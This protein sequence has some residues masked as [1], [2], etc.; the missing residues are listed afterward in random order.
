[1]SLFSMRISPTKRAWMTVTV[2]V[3]MVLGAT[4][5]YAYRAH[6]YPDVVN[7]GSIPEI[8]HLLP[9]NAPAIMYIDLAALRNTPGSP[10]AGIL[11]SDIKA[12]QAD[13][14]YADFVRDTGFDYQRDLDRAG[15]AFWPVLGK[16]PSDTAGRGQML[17]VAEGRFD[18]QKIGAYAL[19]TGKAISQG[20]HSLYEVPGN[21]AT[22]FEFLS[23][24]RIL[25]ASGQESVNLLNDK[26]EAPFG[27]EADP[28]AEQAQ[29]ES[30]SR[31]G[32]AP[33]FAIVRTTGLPES[34]YDNFRGSP[35][36]GSLLHGLQ[37]IALSG[38]PQGDHVQVVLDGECDSMKT[39]IQIA[40]LL[41]FSR[42]GASMFL[43]NAKSQTQLGM[44]QTEVLRGMLNQVKVSND[45]RWV[46]LSLDL[47]PQTLGQESSL[48]KAKP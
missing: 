37:S 46:R 17:I 39:A 9:A 16:Q 26:A 12:R 29:R 21:P 38:I 18:E 22:A 5:I 30:L 24:T 32:G 42:A 10:L 43:S 47:T 20:N 15:I 48:S 2:I 4:A 33:L 34:V 3:C 45:D 14:D 13:R 23:P 44:H 25:L 27:S 7:A 1:M 8:L 11:G 36:I 40:T 28:A 35:Q 41:E 19:R 6:R 31:V